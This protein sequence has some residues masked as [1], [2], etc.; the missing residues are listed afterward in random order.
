MNTEISKEKSYMLEGVASQEDPITLEDEESIFQKLRRR[1][2]RFMIQDQTKTLIVKI[3]KTFTGYGWAGKY[4]HDSC[5]FAKYHK[6]DETSPY[7]R[8]TQLEERR[9]INHDQTTKYFRSIVRFDHHHGT[10]EDLQNIK[11]LSTILGME[12]K[13]HE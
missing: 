12:V 1:I 2:T 4:N 11:E 10:E 13:I 5:I 7:S 8:L 9:V 3:T 6:A